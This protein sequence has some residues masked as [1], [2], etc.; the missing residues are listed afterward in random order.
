MQ[1]LENNQTDG[2]ARALS[3]NPSL[4][5]DV[6]LEHRS[7][8]RSSLVLPFHLRFNPDPEHTWQSRVVRPRQQS[9]A[10]WVRPEHSPLNLFRRCRRIQ[11]RRAE[12]CVS[13]IR[14]PRRGWRSRPGPA[15]KRAHCHLPPTSSTHRPN[16][17]NIPLQRPRTRSSDHS[18]AHPSA[19]RRS[20]ARATNRHLIR[21]R[22][23][24]GRARCGQPSVEA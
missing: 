8:P 17:R 2:S 20:P 23:G 11:N 9:G 1:H 3:Y 7:Q 24:Q 13:G 16:H 19:P 10:N 12:P 4:H 5:R 6:V 15:A 18:R 22:N 14:T 21:A